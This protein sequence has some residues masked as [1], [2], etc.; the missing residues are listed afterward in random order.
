MTIYLISLDD[1]AKKR[2]KMDDKDKRVCMCC[3]IESK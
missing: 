2:A 1:Q 3:E